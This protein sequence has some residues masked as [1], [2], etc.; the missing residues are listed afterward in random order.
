[1]TNRNSVNNDFMIYCIIVLSLLIILSLLIAFRKESEYP[2]FMSISDLAQN[3]RVIERTGRGVSTLRLKNTLIY[4]YRL[5]LKKLSKGKELYSFEKWLADNH[6]KLLATLAECQRAHFYRLPHSFSVPRI[7]IIAR[8]AVNRGYDT[9]IQN[10]M[11]FLKIRIILV[12][13]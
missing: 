9:S 3:V 11:D 8:F 2:E 6:Y 12:L 13:M 1:M 5:I 7:I 4:Q 10:L